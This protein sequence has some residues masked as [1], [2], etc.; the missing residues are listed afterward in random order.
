MAHDARGGLGN[1]HG[2]IADAFK[3]A[4]DARNCEQ[5]PEVGSHGGLQGEQALDAL[6]N[7]NL[8]LVDGVFFVEDGFGHALVGVQNGVDG[9]MDGAFGEAAH[10]QQALLEFFEILLPVAFH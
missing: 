2:L 1:I 9:L 8:H 4:I 10:P 5:K 6:V 3:V 7:F